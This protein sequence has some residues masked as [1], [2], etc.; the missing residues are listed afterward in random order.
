MFATAATLLI[1]P[2][3]F[4]SLRNGFYALHVVLVIGCIW[5]FMQMATTPV[6]PFTPQ[7]FSILLTLHLPFIN[8][9]TF[10][11]YGYDKSAAK[12]RAWRVPERS[13]NMLAFLGGTIGALTGQQVFKHKT[14][15][16]SFRIAF[17]VATWLQ[18][19]V[20]FALF[21]VAKS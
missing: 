16:G 21:V 10:A 1:F 5:A 13:L 12:R 20:I 17:W 3:L 4:P 14:R 6:A 8:L 19:V 7:A 15:K 2:A 9:I 11:A 18:V